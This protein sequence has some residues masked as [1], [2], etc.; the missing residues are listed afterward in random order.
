MCG[1]VL[2]MGS[3]LM[4]ASRNRLLDLL[5][6]L[7]FA[8]REVTLV[9]GKK[10]DFYVDCKQTTLS[11]EGHVLVGR[12]VLACIDGYERREGRSIGGVGGLTLGADPI[13]SAVSLTSALA[14]R[15]IPAFVVR[16]QAKG[17]GT[18]AWL[19]GARN[20]E[21]GAEVVIVEDVCTTGASALAAV[22]RVREAG[23]VVRLVVCLVDRLEGGRP[24]VE[25]ADVEMVALFDREDFPKGATDA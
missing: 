10:S 3:D 22:E 7:S 12:L 20:L 6:E 14:G 16:K 24:A 2:P 21:D 13:A 11:A 5:T 19:E 1:R 23:Y 15:P 9:S 18:G 25:A 8:L 17:H 4:K